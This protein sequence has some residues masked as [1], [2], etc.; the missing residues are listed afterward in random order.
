MALALYQPEPPAGQEAPT[1]KI[2]ISLPVRTIAEQMVEVLRRCGLFRLG[3]SR[4]VVTVD[5]IGRIQQ[6]EPVRFCSWVEEWLITY[7]FRNNHEQEMTMGKDLAAK[8]LASDQFIGGLP[9][10]EVVAPVRLPVWVGDKVELMQPGFDPL[11]GIYCCDAV[12][13][14]ADMTLKEAAAVFQE[15]LGE[16]EFPDGRWTQSRSG[17][18]QVAAMLSTYCR[19]LVPVGAPRP[20]LVYTANQPGSGKSLL[21][22]MALAPVW[23]DPGSTDFPLNEKG[24][25]DTAELRKELGTAAIERR[26]YVWLDDAPPTIYSNSLNR[27]VTSSRHRGRILGTAGSFDEPNVSQVFLTGNMLEITP[28]LMRRALVCELFVAGEVGERRFK[29]EIDATWLA[30]SANRARILAAMWAFVKSWAQD[31]AELHPCPKPPGFAQWA[32]VIGG[33]TA[34]LVG[35]PLAAPDLPTAGDQEGG[36][37]RQLLCSLASDLMDGEAAAFTVDQLVARARSM[38]ILID[39][40]GVTDGPPLKAAERKRLGRRLAPW[41]GRQLRDSRG[42]LFHF[43][44]R[45]QEKGTVYPIAWV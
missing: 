43:G 4:H 21:A 17:A 12:E 24:R 23:G 6:M 3:D 8:I 19:H 35:D 25:V 14:R 37:F 42:R 11:N 31:G 40:V 18:V 36:E 45:K 28:D 2:D 27:F 22:N 15:L 7:R 33:I 26:A 39:L 9:K 10:L 16:F 29:T 38:E 32:G 30:H 13:Y 44:A 20:M 5:D 41:R 34:K 1:P